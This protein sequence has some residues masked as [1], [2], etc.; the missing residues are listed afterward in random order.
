M[1]CHRCGRERAPYYTMQCTDFKGIY[2]VELCADCFITLQDMPRI[3]HAQKSMFK[4]G[5]HK[6]QY[7]VEVVRE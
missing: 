1:K 2:T 5:T 6:Y 3:R 7:K 4:Y